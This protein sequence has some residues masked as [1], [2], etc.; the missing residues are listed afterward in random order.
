MN[1]LRKASML[2]LFA[3]T[4]AACESTPL[5]YEPKAEDPLDGYKGTLQQAGA[6]TEVDWGPKQEYLLS[7]YTTLRDQHD[8]L[9]K[10]FKALQDENANLKLRLTGE[11]DSLSRERA[12]RA[13][14]EAEVTSLQTKR[15]ELEARILSLGIEKAKLE[16]AALLA[17]IADLQR[18]LEPAQTPTVDTPAAPHGGRQ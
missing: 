1:M 4:F 10:E 14:A 15:R 9:Q 11:G 17:K 6:N 16:Q 13:Q 7:G 3:I 2:L 12:L 5:G 18:Q 8:K